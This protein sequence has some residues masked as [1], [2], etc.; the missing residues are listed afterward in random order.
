[1][2]YPQWSFDVE[3]VPSAYR[4]EWTRAEAFVQL[5]RG[6]LEGEGPTTAAT[7]AGALSVPGAD[8]DAALVT[9][10]AE[11]FALRGQFE[12]KTRDLGPVTWGEE[13]HAT[14]SQPSSPEPQAP[15]PQWCERRLLARIH[16][17]TVKRLR[18]EIE[19][20]QARDF[21]RFLLD[22]Q[23]V[24]GD[25][26]MQ[27]P[28]AVAAVLNQLEGFDV[29]AGAWETEVLPARIAE[30]EP[31]WLDEHCLAGRYIWTRLAPRTGT[32]ERAASP[33][34]ATPIVL[35]PRRDARLWSTLTTAPPLEQLS[36]KARAVLEI[37]REHGASF[38]DELVDGAHLLPAQ[39]E[40]ALA[41]LVA[42][43]WVNADSFTGL[44]ALLLPGERRRSS[45]RRRGRAAL[46]G[47]QDAGR[48]ALVRRGTELTANP[49]EHI[50]R[51]LLQRW[52]VVFWKVYQ[53]E[54][55]WLPPWRELLLCYRRLEAR[56]EIRGG[57][58]VAGFSGEQYATPEAI[59]ALREARRRA[60]DDA[61]ISL[62]AADPLNVVGLLTPGARV[63]ALTGNRVLYQ[64]GVPVAALIAGEVTFFETFDSSTQWQARNALLRRHIPG[65]LADLA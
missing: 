26:R 64:D 43:G 52:G 20:V 10:K 33:V 27:G 7:L 11:G 25:A 8:V 42:C 16:R 51:T 4:R 6:R 50:A 13:S 49:V 24:T 9:L 2:L 12:E 63:P 47:M 29:P 22:W 5:V 58:F 38:F 40:E 41:E 19:P 44:R 39:V 21:L 62:S 14:A 35:L 37:I 36:S 32:G 56:G 34:R 31:A 3:R 23:R 55:S 48:W 45:G 65:V 54:A 15:C 61:W 57:R 18:A 30:Y 17:Y 53:R 28:D 46:F 59:G 60:G 1:M